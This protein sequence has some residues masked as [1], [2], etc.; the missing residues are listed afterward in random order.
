[1]YSNSD[2]IEQYRRRFTEGLREIAEGMHLDT[3]EARESCLAGLRRHNNFQLAYQGHDVRELQ[4]M[5]GGIA[6]RIMAANYPDWVQPPPMPPDDG[7]LRIGYVS[8]NLR[9][10]SVAKDHLGWLEEHNRDRFQVFSY[11][12]GSEMDART[13][14]ARRA[15]FRFRHLP[16]DFE[17]TCRAILSDQ[18]HVL[19]FLD[20]GM[21]PRMTQL[22]ALRLAPVQCTTWGHPVTSGLPTI[23]YYLSSDLME[24]EG[25]QSFYTEKLVNLPGVGICYRKPVLPK[26]L[27]YKTRADFGIREDAVAYLSCQSTIKYLPQHD[28]VFPAIAKLVPNAQ[29]VFVAWNDALKNDFQ[30]RLNSAFS[31]AGVPISDHIVFVPTV[32]EISYWNLNVL[33]DI[34]LDNI[35]WSGCNSTFEAVACKLPVVTLPGRFMRGRHSYAILTQLGVTDTIAR[36]KSNYVE[37]A[38]NLALDREWRERVVERMVAGYPA[39]YSD[40]SSVLALENF[41]QQIVRERLLTHKPEMVQGHS[42]ALSVAS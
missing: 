21:D 26:A 42:P 30:K 33:C 6:H 31:A 7:R 22:G 10:H 38:A 15:S 11:Y 32:D 16:D 1:M 39:L 17:E 13:E 9:N 23:D 41:Y 24:P 35:E 5:Y 8:S 3:P 4:A 20:I 40:K 27:F 19:F 25:A 2:E 14:D 36:D 28:D 29:F 37:I 34:F 12:L 18:L